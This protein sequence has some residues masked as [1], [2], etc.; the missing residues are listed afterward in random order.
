MG[1][2][3]SLGI[4][5]NW[6]SITTAIVAV[7]AYG[8]FRHDRWSKMT[9]LEKYLKTEKA[10]RSDNGQRSV[11]HLMARL[12]MTEADV[13]GAAFRSKRIDS[14]LSP[15]EKGRANAILFQYV[16]C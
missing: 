15:D 10:T 6:A 8:H 2:E 4:A 9:A 13:L 16:D 12:S 5:A 14:V 3:S 11:T 1:Y 7:V